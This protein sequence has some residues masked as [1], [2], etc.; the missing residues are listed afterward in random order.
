M[1]DI[2]QDA[3]AQVP[4]LFQQSQKRVGSSMGVSLVVHA[5]VIALFIYI[6]NHPTVQHVA[7]ALIPDVLPKDIVWLDMKGPGGGGGGGGNKMKEPPPK[8]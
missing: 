6:A 8:A 4:F 2:R 7:T 3:P 1:T 5:V